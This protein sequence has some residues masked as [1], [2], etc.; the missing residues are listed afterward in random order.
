M[1]LDVYLD[2][3]TINSRKVLAGLD[4]IKTVY[5]Y[6]FINYFE[7]QW[8]SFDRNRITADLVKANRRVRNLS[9]STPWPRSRPQ[10]MVI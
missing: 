6:H 9:K 5:T 7:G 10:S 8:T 1:P 3:C 2:P 4:L